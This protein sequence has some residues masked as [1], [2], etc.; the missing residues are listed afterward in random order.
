MQERLHYVDVVPR[1]PATPALGDKHGIAAG[2]CM[3]VEAAEWVIERTLQAYW[4]AW[5]SDGNDTTTP[6]IG[7]ALLRVP[8]SLHDR[9]GDTPTA[10]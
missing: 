6:R 3:I 5:S 8:V 10:R 2:G 9:A 7:P 1:Y 4:T